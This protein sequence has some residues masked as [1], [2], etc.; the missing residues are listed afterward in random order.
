MMVLCERENR[1][2]DRKCTVYRGVL[3]RGISITTIRRLRTWRHPSTRVWRPRSRRRAPTSVAAIGHL[4]TRRD[5]PAADRGAVR[6][7]RARR[8]T[9]G[10]LRHRDRLAWAGLVERVGDGPVVRI[11][12]GR[13]WIVAERLVLVVRWQRRNRVRVVEVGHRVSCRGGRIPE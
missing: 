9:P 8:A 6:K 1:R 5:A 4:W 11:V 10:E 3:A 2:Q 12:E 13:V 7:A